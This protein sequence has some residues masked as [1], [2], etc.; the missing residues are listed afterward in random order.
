MLVWC[1]TKCTTRREL[2][3]RRKRRKLACTL[4]AS[5]E[6]EEEWEQQVGWSRAARGRRQVLAD[7]QEDAPEEAGAEQARESGK[8][9]ALRDRAAA[10]T[11]GMR[12]ML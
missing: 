1:S 3:L 2:A 10:E 4:D 5:T 11:Y 12:Q 7:G 9:Q 8:A 6:K